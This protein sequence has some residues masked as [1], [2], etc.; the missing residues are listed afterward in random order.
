[1]ETSIFP[2]EGK[3]VENRNFLP[4]E[5]STNLHFFNDGTGKDAGGV[6]FQ[7]TSVSGCKKTDHGIIL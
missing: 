5:E 4:L 7:I 2:E 3:Y 1:M 6:C